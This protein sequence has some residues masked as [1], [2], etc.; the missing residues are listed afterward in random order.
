MKEFCCSSSFNVKLHNTH[1][2][3]NPISVEYL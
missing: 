1:E 3:L 2:Y